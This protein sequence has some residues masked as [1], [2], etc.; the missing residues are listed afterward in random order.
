MPLH[1]GVPGALPDGGVIR[2]RALRF[3]LG[4]HHKTIYLHRSSKLLSVCRFFHCRRGAPRRRIKALTGMKHHVRPDKCT[5]GLGDMVPRD[6][7]SRLCGERSTT[8]NLPE[9]HPTLETWCP[10]R[11]D[12]GLDGGEAPRPTRR[13]P[14]RAGR[15]GAPRRRIKPLTGGRHHVR[16]AECP[17]EPGDVVPRDER[18]SL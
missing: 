14:V 18:S 3:H 12:Q 16:P 7:G 17:A 9:A 15:R 6:E 4:N 1:A 8:P 13:I 10:A 11:E 2:E 5:A